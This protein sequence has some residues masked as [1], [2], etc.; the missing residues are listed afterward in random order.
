[1]G[2]F[3]SHHLQVVPRRSAVCRLQGRK[4]QWAMANPG[5]GQVPQTLEDDKMSNG[6]N[7]KPLRTLIFV[8]SCCL[9]LL[10]M[11]AAL[12][13]SNETPGIL[14]PD[15][16]ATAPTIKKNPNSIAIPGYEML[17]LKANSKEQTM[18]LPNPPQNDCYFQISLYLEDGTLLWQSELI[19]PGETS[20]PMVLSEVLKKGTYPN[21]VLHYSC[22]RMDESL[23]PLNGAEMKVT[24][25]VK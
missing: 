6:K 20:K 17:E 11:V 1:M 2:L 7:A 25:W 15:N 22:Y 4:N 10:L 12:L 5:G 16:G 24:L 14:A 8:L 3:G 21:A 9:V 23:T 19:A 13:H 18:C